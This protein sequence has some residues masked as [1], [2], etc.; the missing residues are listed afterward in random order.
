[1]PR[2][3]DVFNQLVM[4][5]MPAEDVADLEAL[6]VLQEVMEDLVEAQRKERALESQEMTSD[7]L[8]D[9]NLSD[10]DKARLSGVM[11]KMAFGFVQGAVWNALILTGAGLALLM[12]LSLQGR[13]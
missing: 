7:V 1:M 10:E 9:L 11:E 6:A 5:G 8:D 2:I 3:H 12:L 4:R 13:G